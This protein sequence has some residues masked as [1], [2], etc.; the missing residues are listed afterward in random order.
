METLVLPQPALYVF[1]FVRRIVIA[2][3]VDFLASRHGLI[4]HTQEA[5]PLLMPVLLLA[6]AEDLA[7][8]GVEC[9]KQGCGSI[10][11]I[12]VRHG[13][14]ASLLHRQ[15]GLGAIERLYLAL[16]VHAQ[17]QRVFRRI[18]IQPDDR[19][20]FA[21]ELRIVADFEA[22]DAMRLEA[23]G[24]PDPSNRGVGDAHF[25]GHRAPR[26]MGCVD[27]PALRRLL[28]YLRNDARGN[29]WLPSWPCGVPQ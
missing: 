14:T 11:L 25:A 2:D 6:Q 15:T 10:A 12:V 19:F 9:S 28:N 27:R 5:E 8:S 29:R 4:D 24:L 20:Q 22:V 3:Q 1:V 26:P 16:L 18:Q 21:G 23:V 7:I 17:Q 13:C